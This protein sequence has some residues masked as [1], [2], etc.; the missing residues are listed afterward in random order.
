MTDRP[1][2]LVL[3]VGVPKSPVGA[4]F[5]LI[6]TPVNVY[7]EFAKVHVTPFCVAR[8]TGTGS[9]LLDALPLLTVTV[10]VA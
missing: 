2:L 8:L 10:Q 4:E 6:W 3:I 9:G 7:P 5:P 1:A